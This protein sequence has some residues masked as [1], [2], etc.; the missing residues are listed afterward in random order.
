MRIRCDTVGTYWWKSKWKRPRCSK[1]KREPHEWV[2][3]TV[4]WEDVFLGDLVLRD[5]FKAFPAKKNNNYCHGW[6]T[7]GRAPGENCKYRDRRRK[8]KVLIMPSLL[9]KEWVFCD[10]GLKQFTA[11]QDDQTW[12]SRR[13]AL[14]FK[15]SSDTE[16]VR[17][18][19]LHCRSV[20]DLLNNWH[21]M[22]GVK[23]NGISREEFL[24][25]LTNCISG[26]YFYLLLQ[27]ITDHCERKGWLKLKSG[28]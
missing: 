5:Q 27:L 19:A 9:Q 16:S 1:R 18:L 6:A 11:Y 3:K 13:L 23:S 21:L 4:L 25:S 7:R 24:S 20:L 12:M 8:K 15:P 2:Q 26:G 17:L 10:A 28:N 22:E 14:S